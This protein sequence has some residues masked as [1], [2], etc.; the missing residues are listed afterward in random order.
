[1]SLSG[2]HLP[3]HVLKRAFGTDCFEV[4]YQSISHGM[5]AHKNTT[6]KEV[7]MNEALPPVVRDGGQWCSSEKKSLTPE[8]YIPMQPTS[9]SKRR[10]TTHCKDE[11]FE[12]LIKQEAY[13][14]EWLRSHGILPQC[15]P[16]G[17]RP[18]GTVYL[19]GVFDL[20]HVGHLN[21]IEQAA[22]LGDRL[23]VGVTGDDDATGYKRKPII[24][25]VRFNR[26]SRPKR[27]GAK[28]VN[29]HTYRMNGL[30]SSSP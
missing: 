24:S 23:I 11:L 30:K 28:T 22:N 29:E 20:F 12:F 25:Q 2:P 9:T 4:Y 17:T 13:E 1:M 26:W 10:H 5:K 21:A 15:R 7:V 27:K 3:I 14:K 6:N 16:K 8:H 18:K 19:D